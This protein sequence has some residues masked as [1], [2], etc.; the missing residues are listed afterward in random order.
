MADSLFQR[1]VGLE[2][3][4]FWI[5]WGNF[6]SWVARTKG[7]FS[8]AVGVILC[9]A[10]WSLTDSQIHAVIRRSG[11]S[12]QLG[13]VAILAYRLG[14]LQQHFETT[15]WWSKP[16]AWIRDFP[17]RFKPE[18]QIAHGE[19][20]TVKVSAQPGTVERSHETLEEKVERLDRQVGNLKERLDETKT[21]LL[22]KH[23]TL[24]DDFEEYKERQS[25]KMDQFQNA[26]QEVTLGDLWMEGVALG[27]LFL[28]PL[29][30]TEPRI[31]AHF[32]RYLLIF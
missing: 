9:L 12:L 26:L 14:V 10:V 28:G 24:R 25:E 5:W 15:P 21:E 17:T 27:W 11:L 4:Y 7:V 13:A 8:F 3:R 6:K 30:V 20:A 19:P 32:L 2:Q 31:A 16:W 23:D 18:P 22:E 1:V 29:M